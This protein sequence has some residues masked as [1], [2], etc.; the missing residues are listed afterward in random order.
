MMMEI[1]L[2]AH[3]YPEDGRHTSDSSV[4]DVQAVIWTGRTLYIL[5]SLRTTS[6]LAQ[7]LDVT[8]YFSIGHPNMDGPLPSLKRRYLDQNFQSV[9]RRN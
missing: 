3:L 8:K 6:E 5:M 1:S 7:P 9:T 2:V 4:S